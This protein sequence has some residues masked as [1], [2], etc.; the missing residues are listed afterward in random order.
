MK[1]VRVATFRVAETGGGQEGSWRRLVSLWF[2]SVFG[3]YRSIELYAATGIPS[4]SVFH[5]NE[6]FIQRKVLTKS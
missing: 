1:A 2:A 6:T 5:A 3:L 4:K